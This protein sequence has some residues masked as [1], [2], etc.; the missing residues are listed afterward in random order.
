MKNHGF[1][2]FS[3][4][5]SIEDEIA[6]RLA[7]LGPTPKQRDLA[8]LQKLELEVSSMDFDCG[9]L[10]LGTLTE[11]ENELA[12]KFIR[13]NKEELGRLPNASE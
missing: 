6:S 9:V 2:A 5:A 7:V 12:E 4:V 13:K 10:T 8:K 11:V 1:D 3:S